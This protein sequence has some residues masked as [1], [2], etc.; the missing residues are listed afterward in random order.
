MY[1]CVCNHGT[2]YYIIH[3]YPIAWVDQ[4]AT[5]GITW[6]NHEQLLSSP[7]YTPDVCIL[8]IK[9][10]KNLFECFNAYGVIKDEQINILHRNH[11]ILA[12]F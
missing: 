7:G 2:L 4:S 12:V 6:I 10:R 1:V 11:D 8:S 3:I 9:T 5:R